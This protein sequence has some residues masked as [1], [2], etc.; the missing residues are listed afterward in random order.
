MYRDNQLGRVIAGDWM[1]Q[2]FLNVYLNLLVYYVNNVTLSIINQPT[3]ILVMLHTIFESILKS[4]HNLFFATKNRIWI[5]LT[6]AKRS[7][8]YMTIL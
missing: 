8:K 2:K 7:N 1:D 3:E 6:I 5:T 4:L